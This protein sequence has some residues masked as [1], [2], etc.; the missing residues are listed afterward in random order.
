MNPIVGIGTVVEISGHKMRVKKITKDG[1]VVEY[2]GSDIKISRIVI[3]QAVF[4]TAAIV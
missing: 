1:V 3:E 2:Q 4:N